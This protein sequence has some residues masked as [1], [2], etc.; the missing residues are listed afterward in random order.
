[1][2]GWISQAMVKMSVFHNFKATKRTSELLNKNMSLD[3]IFHFEAMRLVQ[4]LY[5]KQFQ[6]ALSHQLKTKLQAQNEAIGSKV[7]KMN[8]K[9]VTGTTD[10]NM[11]NHSLVFGIHQQISSSIS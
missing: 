4:L 1:M 9:H 5:R 3:T 8:S 10:G 2:K 6:Q 7:S 11:N